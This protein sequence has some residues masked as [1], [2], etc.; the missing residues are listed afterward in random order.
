[1]RV[2]LWAFASLAVLSAEA[3]YAQSDATPPRTES[4]EEIVVRG[5]RLAEFRVEVQLARERAYAIFNEINSTD[6]FDISCDS[7][8]RTGTRVGRDVCAARFE[9]RISSRAAK[10]YLAAMRL[11][12]NGP[13]QRYEEERNRPRGERTRDRREEP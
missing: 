2:V 5:K 9:G 8:M 11:V 7:Q 10:D 6:D 4:P 1:M 12:C 3:A 13:H